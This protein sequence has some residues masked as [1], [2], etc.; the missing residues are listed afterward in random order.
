MSDRWTAKFGQIDAENSHTGYAA[1]ELQHLSTM[2]QCALLSI[3]T[4]G[5]ANAAVKNHGG[6]GI[7]VRQPDGYTHSSSLHVWAC[8][9]NYRAELTAL[10]DV[11]DS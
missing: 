11:V 4:N 7:F 3:C 1:R 5:S 2:S 6:C 8:S 10:R 9:S